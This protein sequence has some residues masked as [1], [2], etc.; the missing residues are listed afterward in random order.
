VSKLFVH[1]LPDYD[2]LAPILSEHGAADCPKARDL[3]DR[4]LTVSNTHW[5]DETTFALIVETLR[6]SL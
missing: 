1:A 6:R 3:A 2:F 5:L 4:M